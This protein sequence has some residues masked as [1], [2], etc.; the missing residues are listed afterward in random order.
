MIIDTEW[1]GLGDK[2]EVDFVRNEY[3]K[4]VDAKSV[5]PGVQA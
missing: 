2:G 1:G 4:I 3:D 5:H